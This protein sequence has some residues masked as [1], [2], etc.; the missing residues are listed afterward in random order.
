VGGNLR[1]L[2]PK[3][4]SNP[5]PKFHDEEGR[6]IAASE[7]FTPSSRLL[8]RKSQS[9]GGSDLILRRISDEAAEKELAYLTL[10]A[11]TPRAVS[12]LMG[13]PRTVR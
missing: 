6:Q 9:S 7:E 12:R 1:I 5:V 13:I 8:R 4:E 2:K 10:P 3:L 11:S